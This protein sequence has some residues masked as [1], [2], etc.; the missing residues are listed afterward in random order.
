RMHASMP[1]DQAR[2][3]STADL[4]VAVDGQWGRDERVQISAGLYN[5]EGW[6][7]G[8]GDGGKDLMVRATVRLLDSDDPS[9]TGG[10]RLTGYG[11]LGRPTGGGDRHRA[12]A[13]LTWQSRRLSVGGQLLL[14][15]DRTD[16]VEG[17][18]GTARDARL[19]TG[20][21]VY[22]VPGSTVALLGRLTRLDR[23]RGMA[24][25]EMT[26]VL[27]GISAR[28]APELRVMASVEHTSYTGG[29]PTPDAEAMRRQAKLQMA[30]AF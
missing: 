30:L 2:F 10:L 16:A 19:A 8:T 5:G 7:S 27:G 15:R 28:L 12:L 21:V 22:R 14:A 3:L 20:F 1:A 18:P 24:D 11:H 6:A 29:A 13:M 4:G 9:A 17:E 23:D 26:R 25:D